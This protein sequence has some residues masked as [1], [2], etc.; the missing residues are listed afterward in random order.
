MGHLI[1]ARMPEWLEKG[2][3]VVVTADH[4]MNNL[5]IHVGTEHAQRA[6]SYTHLIIRVKYLLI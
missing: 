5:G 3:Q 1:A 4:G 6:V 2:Y